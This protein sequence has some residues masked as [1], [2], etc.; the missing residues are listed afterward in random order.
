ME[1]KRDTPASKGIESPYVVG[2]RILKAVFGF[3]SCSKKEI[4]IV[5]LELWWSVCS[6]INNY[7]CQKS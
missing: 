3:V 5:P 2:S 7:L 1:I 4:A 6:F